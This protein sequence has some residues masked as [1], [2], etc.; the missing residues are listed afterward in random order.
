MKWIHFTTRIKN[1]ATTK[2]FLQFVQYTLIVTV[3]YQ[4]NSRRE[5]R[6][7]NAYFFM[8]WNAMIFSRNDL[9]ELYSDRAFYYF[10]DYT[11]ERI[12]IIYFSHLKTFS[13]YILSIIFWLVKFPFFFVINC[14]RLTVYVRLWHIIIF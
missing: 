3:A 6:N 2:L 5:R 11:Y 12:T 14:N 9:R 8:C 10:W 1:P 4:F 7:F 13:I